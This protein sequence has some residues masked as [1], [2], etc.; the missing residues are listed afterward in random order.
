MAYE[1]KNLTNAMNI[2]ISNIATA[3]TQRHPAIVNGIID[4]PIVCHP[5]DTL[6]AR[7]GITVSVS[8]THDGIGTIDFTH[9]DTGDC[10][11]NGFHIGDVD[12]VEGVTAEITKRIEAIIGL[13]A[14]NDLI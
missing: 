13:D 12:A 10:V 1:Q 2:W 6:T 9:G 8:M 4:Q 3:F 7:H 5:L 11:L 14:L